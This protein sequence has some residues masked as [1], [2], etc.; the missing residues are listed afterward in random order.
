MWYLGHE[1]RFTNFGHFTN[2]V[3]Q[4]QGSLITISAFEQRFE[5]GLML[6]YRFLQ[7]NN[8][9]G[10][11]IDAFASVDAGYRNVDVDEEY[12]NLFE[13]INQ[14]NFVTSFHLG[15]NIGY[16]FSNR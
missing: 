15:L 4:P 14:S 11:T 1:L 16:M 9:K 3:S 2:I 13:S 6:G 5:Y 8:A 10:I 7:R 12:T